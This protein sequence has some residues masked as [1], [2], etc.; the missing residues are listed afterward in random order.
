MKTPRH[1]FREYDIRGKA[2]RELTSAFCAALGKGIGTYFRRKEILHCSLGF[3]NR[4]HSPRLKESLVEGLCQSGVSC[5]VI[6]MVPTPVQYFSMAAWNMA[7]GVQITG[8]HNPPE[9]NGFKITANGSSLYGEQIQEI[10]RIVQAGQFQLGRGRVSTQDILPDYVH[11]VLDRVKLQKKL[12]VVLDC[13]N[14]MGSEL[15]PQLLS[16]MG[17]EVVPLYCTYDATF[18]HH[19]PDPSVPA[20]MED[21]K[22]RVLQEKADLGI[23]LDGDCDRVGVV[24]EK[25]NLLLG[26]QLLLL[27]SYFL[28]Q[29]VPGAKIL[30]DVKSSRLLQEVIPSWGGSPIM[31]K[32][33]HS[34]I[35]AKLKEEQAA[36]AGEVSGHMYFAHN[37]FGFD[38]GLFGASLACAYA[39]QWGRPL[40]TFFDQF[41]K[42]CSTPEIRVPVPEEEKFAIVERVREELKRE[43]E[44]IA[45]DGVRVETENGW[46]L[47]RASN[48]Q[49]VLVMRFEAKDAQALSQ[50]Q[51][52]FQEAVRAHTTS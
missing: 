30:Y 43:Y 47:L 49:P 13:G 37:Y 21:L 11:A 34:L 28:L 5:T 9:Y 35:K 1:I 33:G 38:D 3:D 52:L 23:A 48:T 46:G 16:A 44:V 2:D 4:S 22:K 18:P 41:P 19:I 32:T 36:L 25:G 8:S 40:S 27:Y 45:L 24:D 6:G 31:W 17:C 42:Y 39:S 50:L 20:Y 12:K 29:K 7:G 15:G 26:D 10:Y 51:S 14:G